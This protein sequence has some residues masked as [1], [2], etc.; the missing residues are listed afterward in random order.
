MFNIQVGEI[1]IAKGAIYGGEV[2]A[3]NE[4]AETVTFKQGNSEMATWA[5]LHYTKVAKLILV[6]HVVTPI[7]IVKL[8]KKT[9]SLSRKDY[10]EL[11]IEIEA[12][13]R[14]ALSADNP[15]EVLETLLC[16]VQQVIATKAS[17]ER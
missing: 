14:H 4:Q 10:Q 13:I 3:I 17:K 6:D 16:K 9:G 5:T 7:P 11:L 8:A 15:A 1:A 12:Q 2:T